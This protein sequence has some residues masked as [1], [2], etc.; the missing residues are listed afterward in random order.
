MP[1]P[2]PFVL[3]L[4]LTVTAGG[5]RAQPP[6]TDADGHA[7][8]PGALF[9]LGSVAW[10]HG[11][12]ISNSALSP[13]GK[14]L[15][16]AGHYSVVVW[17]LASGRVRQRFSFD[18]QF[19]YTQPG[20]T[21]SPDGKRLGYLRHS[22]LA[23]VL[24]VATG[25]E[26]RR[27]TIDFAERDG[28]SSHFCRFSADGAQLVLTRTKRTVF[29][30][31]ATGKEVRALPV[32]RLA[33]LSPDGGIFVR[34]DASERA[35]VLGDAATGEILARWKVG[36]ILTHSQAA[37]FAPDGRTLAVVDDNKEIQVRALPG[38]NVLAAFPL[39]GSAWQQVGRQSRAIYRVGFLSDGKTLWLATVGGVVHRWDW[40][41][42]K[43][44]P[45]LSK[46]PGGVNNLHALPGGKILVS[47]GA[48]GLIR[49]WD[50]QTGKE[51]AAP[52]AFVGWTY[53]ALAP[54][55][56]RAAVGDAAGRLELWD[57]TSGKR[58]RVLR[59]A[60]PAVLRVAFTPD[61]KEVAAALPSGV[62]QFWEAATGKPGR[63]LRWGKEYDRAY[64]YQVQF[65]LDGRLLMLG[66]HEHE[67]KLW[68]LATGKSVWKRRTG[69]AALTPDAKGVA[70]AVG[71]PYAVCV[72][73]DSG[74]ERYRQRFNSRVGE[75]GVSVQRLAFAPDGR[76][77]AVAEHYGVVTLCDGATGKPLRQFQATA[78]FDNPILA[79]RGLSVSAL[80]FSPDGRWLA[81]GGADAG[82]RL[83][84]VASGQELLR[85][86]G[87]EGDV[88]DVAFGTDGRTLLSCG[89]DGQAL[90]W[91]L[92]PAPGARVELEQ[93]WADL[94]ADQALPAFRAVWTLA[95]DP[96][97]P[98]LLRA[99][100]VPVQPLP[101]ER[102]R[103]WI[104]E[105]NSGN[106]KV[107]DAATKSLAAAGDLAR[108]ELEAV[109][110]K[111]P[112]AEVR[113]R[114]AKLLEALDGSPTVEQLRQ[115][116][117]VQALEL[118]GTPAARQ[119]LTEWAGG[120]PGVRL[121]RAAQAALS[122]LRAV[123]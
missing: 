40:A 70:V 121:T 100:V 31:V 74:Q 4:T 62:V 102:L 76:T 38:G 83:W 16:T 43:A 87:H 47:V 79:L 57:A 50:A 5:L 42:K 23:C 25:K 24:D 103:Q 29:L 114:V 96:K 85:L 99:K 48:D 105:L 9:R 91:S 123:P 6:R 55:G 78:T 51:L 66:H 89:R 13:D 97:G 61:G 14:L 21:F 107:R 10:R 59:A 3:A 68:D 46:H 28:F 86:P 84:E 82:V 39:P 19:W 95:E 22:G 15:A 27:F 7:L 35:V 33:L 93:C 63:S 32:G 45:P 80:A 2:L 12:G 34:S 108:A 8:P 75:N 53:A 111:P 88:E 120:A 92:R 110:H 112:T 81:T 37:A 106:F 115:D 49:R 101:R 26:V 36:L 77:L 60:G 67:T 1:R 73:V 17:D 109:Q 104:E 64:I 54:D 90:V 119:V 56:R 116:R 52:A 18:D 98:A 117:A 72:D 69:P 58:L 118:A 94:R 20:L 122:R 44:L 30:D 41:A 11:D 71:G 65:S 113:Q